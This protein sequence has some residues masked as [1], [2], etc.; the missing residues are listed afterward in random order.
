MPENAKR[1][2][3]E[4]IGSEGRLTFNFFDQTVITLFRKDGEEEFSL[5]NPLHIQQPMI[6]MVNAYFRGER[7]NP[8]S[9]EEAL[10]VM[11]LID[12]FTSPSPI[13]DNHLN[14]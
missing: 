13:S 12:R 5:P 3:C 6:E 2:E 1:D 7:E 4:I 10:D 9:L 11:G 14:K 8:C